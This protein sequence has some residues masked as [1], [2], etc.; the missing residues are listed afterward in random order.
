VKFISKL[1]PALC[2]AAACALIPAAARA[3]RTPQLPPTRGDFLVREGRWTEADA[4]FFQQSDRMPR[5]PLARAA[6]GRYLAMK[7]AVR[8]GTV[9]VEEAKKFG[10]DPVMARALLAPM[11]SILE[12]RADA[13]NFRKDTTFSIQASREDGVLFRIGLPRTD[14]SGRVFGTA[15]ASELVWHDIV[16]RPIGLD[17]VN[18]SGRPIGF[19]VFEA[20]VPSIDVRANEMT[21]HAPASPAPSGRTR[22]FPVLRWTDGVQ[23]LMREGEVL[24]LSAALTALRV[25]WW[26]LDLVR[27]VLVVR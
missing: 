16:D 12:F 1:L 14:R 15:D 2:V 20:M 26:Q 11:K 24:P 3:Q 8:P 7:G 23:V 25:R 19:E 5:D 13:A 6:L 21:L 10:L 18:K 27:G 22:R 4:E 9:L 17:S